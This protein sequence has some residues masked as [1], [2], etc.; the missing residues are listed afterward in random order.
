MAKKIIKRVNNNIL[1]IYGDGGQFIQK[2]STAL[3]NAFNEDNIGGTIGAIGNAAAAFIGAG[4]NNA[5]I[6]DTSGIE[7]A[8][9]QQNAYNP[10]ASDNDSLMNE[11]ASLS[12]MGN[13]SA[14]DIRGIGIGNQIINSVGAAGSGVGAG[15]TTAG[16]LG[17]VIGG[18]TGLLSGI[19]GSII[20]SNRAKKKADS[21]NKSIN[22]AYNNNL[23]ALANNANNIGKNNALNTFANFSALGGNLGTPEGEEDNGKK[24]NNKSSDNEFIDRFFEKY[25]KPNEG[26][27]DT[28]YLDTKSVPTI[29]Y[30]L[31]DHNILKDYADITYDDNNKTA[32]EENIKRTKGADGKTIKMSNDKAKEHSFDYI[33]KSIKSAKKNVPNWDSMNDDMKY[34][35]LDYAYQ[36]GNG[37]LTKKKSPKLYE[38]LK[39]KNYIEAA[40]E[41]NAADN[42][43]PRRSSERKRQFLIAAL[44]E[45]E[46]N[47]AFNHLGNSS[48]PVIV[49][50]NRINNDREINNGNTQNFFTDNPQDFFMDSPRNFFI[51]KPYRTYKEYE[52]GGY[53][54]ND[55]LKNRGITFVDNGGT[56]EE[57]PFGGVQMGIGNN[58]KPNLV[59][60]GEVIYNDYV[61]SNRLTADKSLLKKNNIPS[62]YNDYTFA[63]IAE[64]MT[65]EAKERPNDR[66]STNGVL[67]SLERLKNAQEEVRNNIIDDNVFWDGGPYKRYNY[68]NG[69]LQYPYINNNI[70]TNGHEIP[71]LSESEL[72]TAKEPTLPQTNNIVDKLE[73]RIKPQQYSYPTDFSKT[74]SIVDNDTDNY[75]EIFYPYTQKRSALIP[76]DENYTRFRER[77]INIPD[78]QKLTPRKPYL[79]PNEINKLDYRTQD[80]DGDGESDGI[81]FNKNLLKYAPALGSAISLGMNLFSKPDYSSVDKITDAANAISKYNNV[82]YKPVG[83][84]MTYKPMDKNYYTNMLNAQSNATRDAIMNSSSPSRDAMLLAADYNAQNALGDM[85]LKAEQYNDNLRRTVTEFNRGTDAMNSQMALQADM[86]NQNAYINSMKSRLSGIGSAAQLKEAIDANRGQSISSG[87]TTLFDNIG[88]IGRDSENLNNVDMLIESGALGVL[89]QKPYWWSDER[90]EDYK[91]SNITNNNEIDDEPKKCG[92][93][94]TIKKKKKCNKKK[95]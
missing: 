88:N 65:S 27:V 74:P 54:N 92:G 15:A 95:C 57:N 62:S 73:D 87:L 68:K 22:E 85:A 6:A 28:V 16:P 44:G 2:S 77:P 84:Y 78:N 39:E 48:E 5:Q 43:T 67:K 13:V 94:L 11:W 24:S 37:I 26:F 83:N 58:N 23:M 56:H 81:K 18:A 12:K 91:T 46:G 61:F 76:V 89:S 14:K 21:I 34:A 3:K 90:W 40:K 38:A 17:A 31:T 45:E 20:G 64:K 36:A 52:S 79:S 33:R 75:N 63:K 53:M 66:I 30:G 86:A 25:I 59:E 47:I 35:L 10:N 4:V 55:S 8:V 7:S 41:L 50:S 80:K 9:A 93:Y 69:L 49:T 42:I 32:V 19:T 72:L 82:G 1:N 51:D 60:E 29:G 71:T 70:I